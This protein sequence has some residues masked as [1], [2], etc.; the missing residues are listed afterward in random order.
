METLPLLA[1]LVIFGLAIFGVGCLS[2]TAYLLYRKVQR[3]SLADAR[4]LKEATHLVLCSAAFLLIEAGDVGLGQRDPPTVPARDPLGLPAGS[5][6]GLF[7]CGRS[8]AA[9][10]PGAGSAERLRGLPLAD[11]VRREVEL[12]IIRSESGPVTQAPGDVCVQACAI[13]ACA[14]CDFLLHECC[15]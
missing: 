2:V 8:A 3:S 7:Q 5:R 15:S 1:A 6:A 12:V 10:L 14:F 11:L 9:V 13:F 4:F